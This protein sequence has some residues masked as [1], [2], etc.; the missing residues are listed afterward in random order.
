MVV[1]NTLEL[2]IPYMKEVTNR[3]M[4]GVKI[5][6]SKDENV[7]LRE[8]MQEQ[9]SSEPYNDTTLLGDYMETVLLFGYIV[10]KKQLIII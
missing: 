5:E 8:A 4:N 1:G 2:F 6:V 9:K 7:Q 3:Y 10:R